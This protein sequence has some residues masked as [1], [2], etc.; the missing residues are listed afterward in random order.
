MGA[1][2][3]PALPTHPGAPSEAPPAR[4]NAAPPPVH[5][6]G[7]RLSVFFEL[8]VRARELEEVEGPPRPHADGTRRPA[9]TPLTTADVC[10][11]LVKPRTT[12]ARCAYVDSL[13]AS[14]SARAS[15][16]VSH[17]W[18][19]VFVDVVDALAHAATEPDD[20]IWF[21]LLM[22]NQHETANYD[23]AFLEGQFRS[24]VEGVG[25]TLLVLAPWRS[26]ITL[27]RAWCLFE[28]F[29]SVQRG[30]P[31]EVAMP[32]SEAAAFARALVAKFGTIAAA[33]ARISLADSEA[34]LPSDKANI[35]RAL[36]AVGGVGELDKVVQR[37]LR[38]WLARIGR[39]ALAERPADWELTNQLA[40]LLHDQG[41]L[42][43]AEILFRRALEGRER[44]LGTEHADTLQSA[45]NLAVLLHARGAL[46]EAEPLFRRALDGRERQLGTE[47]ALALQS[48]H[49]LAGLLHARGALAEAEPLFRRALD[50]R[51][52][53]LG[54]RDLTALASARNLAVL[55][56][57]R[58]RP[59][60]AEPLLR[61]ALDG[62][63][64][65]L[66]ER[67]PD[68]LRAVHSLAMLLHGQGRPAEA[69]P[70]FRRA[71]EGRERQLGDGHPDTVQSAH[72]LAALLR[73]HGRLDEA[74]P[75]LR[76]ALHSSE[77]SLGERHPDT[78]SAMHNLAVVVK[79]RGQ[80][81]EAEVLHRRA[82]AGQEQALGS[83]HPDALT[84]M[85]SLAALL[86]AQGRLD[87]ALPLFWR[88]LDGCAAVHG[89]S[90]A[91][92]I[93][94]AKNLVRTLDA[95]GRADE[96]Q[97]LRARFGN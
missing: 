17:A 46:A 97:R 86:R 42:S 18:K 27:T 22:N 84:S 37:T 62:T 75:L 81:A 59:D 10:E 78:L 76:R 85:Y 4:V 61:R 14:S 77:R 58:G 60:E 5:P 95:C 39:G 28:I 16:Y 48:A 23:Y 83:R 74:E 7:L 47:H 44:Q 73:A 71:L 52:R 20:G 96:A 64:Q 82:L 79:A 11:E 68:T 92:T 50:G 15:I 65:S 57:A 70:L 69:E 36:A 13:P 94:S 87:E 80:L 25:R 89:E 66:G 38:E 40:R 3:C 1:A 19:Y 33:L 49:N 8:A 53:A 35:L 43:E 12:A 29:V 24:N 32:S 41:E 54:A 88:E 63:E 93:G 31:M 67:H 55:L 90:H 2:L 30:I 26:P 34:F 72:G 21:C 56:E 91:Q 6:L 9:G 51:E 45:S